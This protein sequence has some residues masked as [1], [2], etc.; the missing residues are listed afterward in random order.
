MEVARRVS[1]ELPHVATVE[2]SKNRREKRVYVDV[3]QN[4]RGH[5]FVPPYALRPVSGAPVST[6]LEWHEVAS[7]LDPSDFNI[8]TIF[9]RRARH[10]RDPMAGLF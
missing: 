10:K 6:P 8:K 4:V 1:R 3:M 9:E 2:R 5:H 7:G